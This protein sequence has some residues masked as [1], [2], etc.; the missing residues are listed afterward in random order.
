MPRPW[1]P[2]VDA[3]SP[4]PYLCEACDWVFTGTGDEWERMKWKRAE[5]QTKEK[6]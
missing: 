1:E 3:P 6:P 2:L 4:W 5:H